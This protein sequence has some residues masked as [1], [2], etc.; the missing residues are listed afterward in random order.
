M[1]DCERL[2]QPF[3][4]VVYTLAGTVSL[5]IAGLEVFRRVIGVA[6][7]G[8]H[9]VA[10]QVHSGALFVSYF[11]VLVYDLHL[12]EKSDFLGV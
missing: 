3:Q 2:G 10:E 11:E 6:L 8:Q 5:R 9:R 1:V 4:V 7:H 12:P